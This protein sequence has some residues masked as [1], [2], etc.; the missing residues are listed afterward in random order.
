MNCSLK[1]SA[2]EEEGALKDLDQAGGENV[3][4]N[5]DVM[6]SEKGPYFRPCSL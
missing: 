2:Q 5:A 4:T 1:C 3:R 6:E